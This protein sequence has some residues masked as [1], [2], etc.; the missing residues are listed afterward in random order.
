LLKAVMGFASV[1][2]AAPIVCTEHDGG[3][4]V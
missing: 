1:L 3:G 2:S 4:V